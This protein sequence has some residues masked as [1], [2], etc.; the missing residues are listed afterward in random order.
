VPVEVAVK[1]DDIN[2]AADPAVFAK[3][4]AAVEPLPGH[5]HHGSVETVRMAEHNGHH[6]AVYTTYR[7]EIDG[8]ELSGHIGVSNTGNVHY[9]GLP[10][11]SFTSAV[12]LARTVV[13]SFPDDFPSRTSNEP[14][15]GHEGPQ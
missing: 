11:Y 7:I 4:L 2:Q 5:D 14:G 10:A 3:H 15:H 9:H 12:D 13:D 8:R 1:K 6:I